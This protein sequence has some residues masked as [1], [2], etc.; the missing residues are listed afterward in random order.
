MD[1]ISR[2]LDGRGNNKVGKHGE[3]TIVMV[4]DGKVVTLMDLPTRWRPRMEFNERK[5]KR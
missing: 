2:V 4:A 3:T 5:S 1:H